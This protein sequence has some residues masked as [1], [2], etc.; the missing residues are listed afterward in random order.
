MPHFQWPKP[1]ESGEDTNSRQKVAMKKAGLK[2]QTEG[3]R[4]FGGETQQ[5]AEV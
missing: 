1:Q 2:E 4:L 5:I 3:T